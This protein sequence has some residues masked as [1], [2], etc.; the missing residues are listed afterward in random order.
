M[1]FRKI[2]LGIAMLL[3]AGCS[4]S[5]ATAQSLYTLPDG[6]QARWASAEDPGGEEGKGAQTDGGRKDRPELPIKAGEQVTLAE[7]RLALM[8][9]RKS[10]RPVPVN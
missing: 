4:L 1:Q 7:R 10:R 9:S 2:R 8:M 5:K 3:I 6:V